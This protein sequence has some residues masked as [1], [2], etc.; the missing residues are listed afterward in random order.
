MYLVFTRYVLQLCLVRHVVCTCMFILGADSSMESAVLLACF[1]PHLIPLS[2][3]SASLL[4]TQHTHPAT[5][6]A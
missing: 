6:V 3:V 1:N 4:G 2:Y 5:L